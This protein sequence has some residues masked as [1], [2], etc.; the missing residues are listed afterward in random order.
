[1][2]TSMEFA[3]D[4]TRVNENAAL[5]PGSDAD[6]HEAIAQRAYELYQLRTPGE[7]DSLT[8][9]LQAEAEINATLNAPARQQRGKTAE[10]NDKTLSRASR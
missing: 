4:T 5:T 7:G 8:D 1:M 3:E 10:R 2:T 6:L 9:W